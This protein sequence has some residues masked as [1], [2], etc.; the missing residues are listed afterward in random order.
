LGGVSVDHPWVELT[1]TFREGYPYGLQYA[2]G[3]RNSVSVDN[4]DFLDRLYPDDWYYFEIFNLNFQ[5]FTDQPIE[6]VEFFVII[7][8]QSIYR[9]P[10]LWRDPS[11][12][13]LNHSGEEADND[14]CVH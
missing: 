9:S 12:L 5:S 1:K 10:Y 2:F 14:C 13:A 4:F 8:N 3:N 6:A 11:D 7:A